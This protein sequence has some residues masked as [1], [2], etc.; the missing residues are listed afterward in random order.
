MNTGT[1]SYRQRRERSPGQ[2]INLV[3]Q[4]YLAVLQVS[5]ANNLAYLA[6]VVF[7]AIALLVFI[8]VFLQL[9]TATFA[10]RGVHSLAGFRI[11]DMIWYLAATETIALSLPPLTRQIDSEVRSGQLAYLLGRPCNYVL[12]RF[13]QYF[14]ERVVQ[15]VIN[16]PVAA[17]LALVFVGLP[18]FSWMGIAAWPLVVLLAVSIDFV[19]YF[20]IGLLA[21]W[22]E[23]TTPFFLIVNRLALVLGGVL[24]PLEVLPQPLRGISQ[25]LPFSAVLY[26]P[27]R[28]LV[29]FEPGPFG[30]L[31]LQQVVTLAI[32]SLV[33]LVIYWAAARRVNINGG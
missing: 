21:F 27:A 13:A 28:T 31:L 1:H 2:K 17:A 22:T 11:S 24:A 32:G 26:G 33:L 18:D 4:K 15:L 12:Y 20:S 3:W 23:E 25:V 10:A 29:H 7:R 8:F 30:R 6:E 14:G 19:I 16:M 9:W 5:V